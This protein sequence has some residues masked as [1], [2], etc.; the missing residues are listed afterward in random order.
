MGRG[1]R[2]RGGGGTQVPNSYPL[3]LR[4]E[5]SEHPDIR[6]VNSFEGKNGQAVNLKEHNTKHSGH[7]GQNFAN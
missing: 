5:S 1:G 7:M 4:R 2:A 3:L 6:V